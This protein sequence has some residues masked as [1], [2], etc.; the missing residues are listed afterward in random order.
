FRPAGRGYAHRNW[1]TFRN[2]PP[3]QLLQDGQA[4]PQAG[5]TARLDGSPVQHARPAAAAPET[6][7]EL[8]ESAATPKPSTVLS[9][10]GAASGRAQA[11][12][13]RGR[14]GGWSLFAAFGAGLALAGASPPMGFWP[15]AIVGPALLIPAV[16]RK[17][18][19]PTFALALTCGLVFFFTL[20]SWL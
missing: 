17:R 20:L 4:A 13:W 18:L 11:P 2:Q 9:R 16:W 14:N 15:L 3:E 19:L 6:A 10:L 12:G 5:K 1:S 7:P 8:P